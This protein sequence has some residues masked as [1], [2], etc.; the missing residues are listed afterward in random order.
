[1]PRNISFSIVYYCSEI[2]PSDI[3]ER[4]PSLLEA[5]HHSMKSLELGYS[6]RVG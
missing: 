3:I 6:G 4:D 2:V 5:S 1:M